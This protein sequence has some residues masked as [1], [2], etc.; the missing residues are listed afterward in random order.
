MDQNSE[1]QGTVRAV[2][3]NILEDKDVSLETRVARAKAL[4]LI[5]D[6]FVSMTRTEA[7]AEEARV[8]EELVAEA[9]K[10]REKKKTP[11]E[12]EQ[13]QERAEHAS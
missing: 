8:F 11:T 7:E 6:V 3:D 1:I 5:G 10:K 4:R 2:C 13:Q 9:S 12:A